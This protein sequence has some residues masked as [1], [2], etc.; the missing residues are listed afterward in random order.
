MGLH[1]KKI[2]RAVFLKIKKHWGMVVL[3]GNNVLS[4]VDNTVLVTAVYV[5]ENVY[6]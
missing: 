5:G 1:T 6:D 2:G 4:T 3:Q